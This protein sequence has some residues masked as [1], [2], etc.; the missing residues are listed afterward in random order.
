MRGPNPTPRAT[1]P[2]SIEGVLETLRRGPRHLPRNPRAAIEAAVKQLLMV[3]VTPGGG[4]RRDAP[5]TYRIDDL[6]RASGTTVRN[7]RAYQERGLLHAPKR[8]GRTAVFDDSHLSRLKI[9][10]SM[11]ERGYTTAHILEM[12]SAWE[13]GRDL[14]D[15]LGLEHALVPAQ[16]E[17][18]PTSMTLTAARA[19]AGGPAEL[20]RL[21]RA[22]L[23]QLTGSR[24]RVLR[25]KLVAAFAEMR[26]HG[27]SMD[28]LVELHLQLVPA[29]DGISQSLVA[30]GVELLGHRFE[31]D[32]PPTS[33][34]VA[35]LV[36]L[37]T[38]FRTLALTSVTDTLANSIEQTIEGL[39]AEYLAHFVRTTETS[40]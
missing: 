1:N 17:D 12:L 6:A 3:G 7:V 23:V 29:I 28:K 21:V 8:V 15:V 27:M 16:T 9:I 18:E 4:S 10:T 30:A 35:E 26:E 34:D 22:G 33:A 40:A 37:L 24:V 2:R 14:S 19:L 13:H 20:D 32:A 25:P 31:S 38:R 5:P 36:T 39:L 11:L